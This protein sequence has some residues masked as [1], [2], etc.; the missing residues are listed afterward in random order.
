[1]TFGR[2]G[3]AA[4]SCEVIAAPAAVRKRRRVV[5]SGNSGYHP[6]PGAR[7]R[8]VVDYLL[9]VALPVEFV[10]LFDPVVEFQP[11]VWSHHEAI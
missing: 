3:G 9:V 1:M 11:A 4:T 10:L 2:L 5:I 6:I 7:R 8:R